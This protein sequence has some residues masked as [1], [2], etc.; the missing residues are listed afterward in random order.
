MTEEVQ[1][2]QQGEQQEPSLYERLG[3]YDV[4]YE[5]AGVVLKRAME[6]PVIGHY[7][8]H[9]TEQ[10]LYKE[11]INFVD[12][13]AS[14]WGGKAVYRGHDMVTAH[15]GMGVTKE[16]F[17]AV[18]DV[19]EGCYDEYDLPQDLRDEVTAFLRKYEPAIVGSPSYKS[20]ILANR[21]MDISKG[22]KSVGVVWPPKPVKVAEP[23]R[24]SDG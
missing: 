21:D 3:G 12:F 17:E 8:D 13:L 1:T 22:M 4:I 14:S 9:A 5:F 18:F 20:V 19:V 15:R 10:S 16:H 11:H 6:N 24:P 23:A 7:W 2:S